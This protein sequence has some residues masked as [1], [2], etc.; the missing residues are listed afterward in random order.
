VSKCTV[1]AVKLDDFVPERVD[2]L[3]ID[4]EGFEMNVPKGATRIIA[5]DR[6]LILTEAANAAEPTV[7][8]FLEGCNYARVMEVRYVE[9]VDTAFRPR[10]GSP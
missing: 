8:A 4:V 2:F 6:S 5:R 7:R 1:R 10:P 9:F 3:K